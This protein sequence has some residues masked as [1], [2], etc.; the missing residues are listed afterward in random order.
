MHRVSTLLFTFCLFSGV[1]FAGC[2]N[3]P[4][5][6]APKASP[7]IGIFLYRG[8]DTYIASVARALEATLADL[9]SLSLHAAQ[10]D[11]LTQNDQL[12]RMLG[13]KPDLLIVNIVDPKNAG[14]VAAKAQQ[15]G[16]PII[17]FNREPD[18][19]AL[20]PY[21]GA[22]F[23]GTRIQD[24][25]IMQGEIIKRLWDKHPEYDRNRDGKVQYIMFQGEPDNPEAL[26]RTEYSV[27]TARDLGVSMSQL[28]G[29]YICGW[30]HERARQAM[31]TA[32]AV[33]GNA[34]ELILANNDSMALGAIAALNAHGYNL[35]NGQAGMFI[36]V[37]GVDAPDEAVAAIK[38]GVMS[39]TVKQDNLAMAEAIGR[40][41]RNALRG[42]NFLDGTPYAWDDT[43]QAI[44]IP[45]SPM[46]Q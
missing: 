31:E 29:T 1:L 2:D 9:G 11:Q 28:G 22:C 20:K 39:A 37:L 33:H 44:R 34:I 27:K 16:I 17:F 23:V 10:N 15:A 40:L 19:N 21:P 36:P 4:P 12:D 7:S 25:G 14:S 41:A 18:L 42:K 43:G 26:A 6:S 46:E 30:D 35:E 32:F 45:Y 13:K 38:R 8:D 5:P 24:A 3:A